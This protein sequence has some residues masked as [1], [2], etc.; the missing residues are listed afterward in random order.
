MFIDLKAKMKI[1]YIMSLLTALTI[2]SNKCDARGHGILSR[3]NDCKEIGLA[4]Y[5]AD[6]CCDDYCNPLEG[7]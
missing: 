7:T 6:D 1:I 4:C 5:T 2:I 3:D